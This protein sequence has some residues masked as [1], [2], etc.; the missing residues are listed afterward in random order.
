[1]S[2]PPL[3]LLD[4]TRLS[5]EPGGEVTLGLRLRNQSSVVDELELEV[6]GAAAGWATVEPPKLSLFPG[7]D[8]RAIVR[9]RPPRSSRL[10]A[11]SL[12]V[13]VRAV[14]T[15]EARRAAVEECQLEVGP[16]RDVAAEL[17]PQS[18]RGRLKGRH[19]LRLRNSGNVSAGVA[20]DATE[21]DGN[22]RVAVEPAQVALGPGQASHVRVTVRPSRTLWFGSAET[23]AF[24]VRAVP[25]GGAE[26][27]LQGT[28]RQGPLVPGPVAAVAV[29][30][31]AVLALVAVLLA[32]GVGLPTGAATSAT[33]T[34]ALG[35]A[36]AAVSVGHSATTAPASLPPSGPTAT[37][38]ST[39][40]PTS[41]PPATGPPTLKAATAPPVGPPT[42]APVTPT[43][44]TL[45]WPSPAD[46]IGYDPTNITVSYNSSFG[47]YQVI[48]GSDALL[49]YQN[50]ADAN[51]GAALARRY[52][53][54]CFVGRSNTCSNRYQ[55]IMD[56]WLGPSNLSSTIAVQDCIPYNRNQ[57]SETPSG[58]D[59]Q[60]SDPTSIIG[61]FSSKADADAA[62]MVLRHTSNICYV[63]RDQTGSN[64]LAY[65]TN[66]FS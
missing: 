34:P 27:K 61:L 47:V 17:R 62:V 35:V 53:Q 20:L 29:A 55:C 44:D 11:G 57:L 6:L 5:V 41:A 31:I 2:D 24:A 48:S 23:F 25:E 15:I 43:P 10:A 33:P 63:G 8:G 66:Y 3:L 36:N 14:S 58:S 50:Q 65:I 12:P 7:T 22:C 9:F 32:R 42:A 40:V 4:S 52:T 19:E 45:P 56:Y 21:L 16:F 37:T 49:A 60:V 1:M 39:S 38:T 54:Q 64:R 51:D 30:V 46:C 26:Q 28:M 13:G 18:S 59:W